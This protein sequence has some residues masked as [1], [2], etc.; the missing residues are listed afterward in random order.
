MKRIQHWFTG[1]EWQFVRNIF[2]PMA[3]LGDWNRTEYRCHCGARKYG[4]LRLK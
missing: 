4:E 1:H 2:G 3:V